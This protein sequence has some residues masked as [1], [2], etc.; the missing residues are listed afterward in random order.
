MFVNLS[1]FANGF[2]VGGKGTKRKWPA[3]D[4]QK[5]FEGGRALRKLMI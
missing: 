5:G 4:F 1:A 3:Q 2:S